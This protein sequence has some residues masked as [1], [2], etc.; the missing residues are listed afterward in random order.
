MI[1]NGKSGRVRKNIPIGTSNYAKRLQYFS[2]KSEPIKNPRKYNDIESQIEVLEK[3]YKK[4]EFKSFDDWVTTASRKIAA[5]GGASV[6]RRVFNMDYQLLLET[7]YPNYPWEFEKRRKISKKYFQSIENQQQYME[8]IFKKLNYKN[9]EDL[10]KIKKTFFY[11]NLGQTLLNQFYDKNIQKLLKTIYPNYP[12]VLEDS[13][14]NIRRNQLENFANQSKFM[15]EIFKKF[16]LNNF[17]DWNSFDP[18]LLGETGRKFLLKEI[19]Q[20]DFKLLLTTIYPNFPFEFNNQN[21]KI[22]MKNFLG[23]PKY[24]LNKISIENYRNLMKQFENIENR[25]ELMEKFYHNFRLQSLSD[26]L[27]IPQSFL[28]RSVKGYVLLHYYNSNF[29][30]LLSNIYPNFPWET[31]KEKSISLSSQYKSIENQKI[32]LDKIFRKL[33]FYSLDQFLKLTKKKFLITANKIEKKVGNY[34]LLIYSLDY[35]YLLKSIYSNHY[36]KF[37][38]KFNSRFSLIENQRQ[39]IENLYKKFQLNNFEELNY[40]S[41]SL[42]LQNKGGEDL[43]SIY[44]YQISLLFQTLYPNFPWN[45][46]KISQIKSIIAQQ[47]LLKMIYFNLSLNSFN[48]LLTI[49]NKE[50]I[51]NGGKEILNLYQ[52]RLDMLT[53]LFPSYLWKI[54]LINSNINFIDYRRNFVESLFY[55]LN[56]ITLEDFHYVTRFKYS[57]NGGRKLIEFYHNDMDKLLQDIFPNYPWQFYNLKVRNNRHLYLMENQKKLMLQI[58]KLLKLKRL[59]DWLKIHPYKLKECGGRDLLVNIYK[60][61]Y[62]LLLKTIYPNH[63]WDFSKVLFPPRITFQS[64]EFQRKFMDD[65]FHVLQFNSMEDWKNISIYTLFKYKG[66]GLLLKYNG[67]INLMLQTIYPEYNWEFEEDK[68]IRDFNNNNYIDYND[69]NDDDEDGERNINIINDKKNEY[70][71]EI[72]K[73][74]ALLKSQRRIMSK[75]FRLFKLK[76]L[77]DWMTV[78]RYKFRQKRAKSLLLFYSFDFKKL[79]Q[80]LYPNHHWDFSKCRF[81]PTGKQYKIY[82]QYVINS[83]RNIYLVREKKDWFRI[84]IRIR[85]FLNM[86]TLPVALRRIFPDEKWPIFL[87]KQRAKKSH[88]RLLFAHLQRHFVKFTLLENYKHPFLENPDPGG[89]LLEFD[90]FIPSINLAVEYQGQHHYNEVV[91]FSGIE[92]LISRDQTKV[93]LAQQFEIYLVLIP[94]WWDLSLS[95]LISTLNANVKYS[96][97]F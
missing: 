22:D 38:I 11:E 37:P 14:I 42:I 47:T 20:N 83:L 50:F 43:L 70:Y 15:E 39:F 58:F 25:R 72:T 85:E 66:K 49:S 57:E 21:E 74:L 4:L 10:K 29:N 19:Y 46:D 55:S 81:K 97:K 89:L 69:D 17:D 92:A 75:L 67:N 5:N 28:L 3:I 95:T 2:T 1:K 23:G 68:L 87:F 7:L 94:Y 71:I 78:S 79:L 63:Q 61:N 48:D 93:A 59:D 51:L 45:F 32:F 76:T 62:Q 31:I 36:W 6:F 8:E 40:I 24:Y 52:H 82:I 12:W 54:R 44:N 80:T 84:N 27:T 35:F 41:I 13:K 53:T 73:K 30:E 60:N 34:L 77:N 65:L 16:K 91:S 96:E 18:K 86:P 56:L 64:M 9:F 90:I 88:Q 33:R 26:W